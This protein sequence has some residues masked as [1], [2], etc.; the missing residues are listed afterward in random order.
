MRKEADEL[1][2]QQMAARKLNLYQNDPKE[3][4]RKRAASKEYYKKHTQEKKVSAKKLYQESPEKK[5]EAMAAYN[6]KHKE[7]INKSMRNQYYQSCSKS[8]LN[9]WTEFM[10]HVCENTFVTKKALDYHVEHSHMDNHSPMTC[11]ICENKFVHKQSL[12]RHT[13]EVHGGVKHTCDKCPAAFTRHTELEKHINEG[14]HYLNFYCKQCK[15]T[16]VFKH[17]GGLINHVIV[18]QSVGEVHSG[19]ETW[20]E[21]KSGILVTCKSQV[22]S[23]QL[24]EGKHVLCMPRK[25]KVEAA[26]QRERKKEEIINEGLQLANSNAEFPRVNFE[27]EYKKHEDDGR[28]KC[29]WCYDHYPYSSEQCAYRKPDTGWHLQRE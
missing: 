23:T 8:G 13:K 10:C 24:K 6:E 11:Q 18:K 29:K 5:K 9:L 15:K 25:E 22:E 20:K 21:Y 17:L 14:W 27:F 26:K 12:E 7:A 4:P 3:S 19:G 2:R 28:R 16:L 1:H